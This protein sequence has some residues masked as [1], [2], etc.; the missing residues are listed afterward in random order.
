MLGA[1]IEKYRGKISEFDYKSVISTL[2]DDF[3]FYSD[4]IRIIKELFDLITYWNKYLN[5]VNHS[6]ALDIIKKCEKEILE[7][8]TICQ[9]SL[10][11]LNQNKYFN[12]NYN[13]IIAF[14]I[15]FKN[16]TNIK[17]INKNLHSLYSQ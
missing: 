2:Q 15:M 9:N 6:Q 4:S 14:K 16:Q 3:Y 10:H 17:K 12:L 13:S 8:S 5:G 1:G 11:L 7:L